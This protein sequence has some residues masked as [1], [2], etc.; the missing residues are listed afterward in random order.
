ML[1]LVSGMSFSRHRTRQIV[2]STAR[3]GLRQCLYW[4]DSVGNEDP[5]PVL[6]DEIAASMT[7]LLQFDQPPEVRRALR[8]YRLGINAPI[9]EDQFQC[10]WFAIRDTGGV[11]EI[12]GQGP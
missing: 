6:D 9:P 10:F 8:W 12:I 4:A 5:H 11:S 3:N 1:A 2:D 7:R